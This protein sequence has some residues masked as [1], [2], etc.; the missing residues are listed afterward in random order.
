LQFLTTNL[1]ESLS[2][3]IAWS[4]SCVTFPR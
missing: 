2:P 3:T 4:W 1:E